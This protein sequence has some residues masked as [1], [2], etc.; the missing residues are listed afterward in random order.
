MLELQTR[1]KNDKR[2][3]LDSRFLD[4]N[5]E[6]NETGNSL[7]NEEISMEEEKKKEYDILEQ[8]LGKKVVPKHKTESG[9]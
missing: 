9:R 3:V 8:I 6:E 4:E 5:N 1:Y 7:E 2:F